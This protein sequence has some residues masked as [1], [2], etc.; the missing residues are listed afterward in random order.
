MKKRMISSAVK[1]IPELAN[2]KNIDNNMAISSGGRFLSYD[3]YYDLLISAAVQRDDTIHV[4]S[5]RTKRA[6]HYSDSRYDREEDWYDRGYL[7]A[8]DSGYQEEDPP[9]LAVNRAFQR[10]NKDA[11]NGTPQRTFIPKE[12]WDLL[13]PEAQRIIRG[14]PDPNQSVPMTRVANVHGVFIDTPP[15]AHEDHDATTEMSAMTTNRELLLVIIRPIMM[16]VTAPICS[17][18]SPNSR[19]FLLVTNFDQYLQRHTLADDPH[20]SQILLPNK[21]KTTNRPSLSMGNA[22]SGPTRIT[23]TTALPLAPRQRRL[24]PW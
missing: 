20:V 9:S 3:Q 19:H 11:G 15:P 13:S 7:D 21:T 8:G 22:M 17:P 14:L 1:L 23:S 10:S 24:L 16:T 12:R 6:V 2:V 5:S 18:T 4:P